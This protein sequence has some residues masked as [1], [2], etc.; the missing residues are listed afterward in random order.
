M[1]V[2]IALAPVAAVMAM[3]APAMA[4]NN[5]SGLTPAQQQARMAT[6]WRTPDA[7]RAEQENMLDEAT[8]NNIA[9]QP[10]ERVDLAN[11]V[12]GLIEQGRCQEA[13]ELARAEGDRQMALRARQLCRPRRG[14]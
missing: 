4:Q 6:P 10:L 3:A 9:A 13:R 7:Y 1:R 12:S 5:P 11:R 8:G 14:G 2:L